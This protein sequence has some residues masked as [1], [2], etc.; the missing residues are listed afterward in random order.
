MR[1]SRKYRISPALLADLSAAVIVNGGDS[2]GAIIHTVDPDYFGDYLVEVVGLTDDS[3]FDDVCKMA[4]LAEQGKAVLLPARNKESRH[5]YL[6]GDNVEFKAKLYHIGAWTNPQYG[7][8][9]IHRFITLD[10]ARYEITWMTGKVQP[11]GRYK[12]ACK[13]KDHQKYGGIEQ[14]SVSY[15]KFELLED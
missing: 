8:Q 12:V 5:C 13:V 3:Y 2:P 15:C 9:Y 1:T 4:Y 14:T 10:R 6:K 11:I 7:V